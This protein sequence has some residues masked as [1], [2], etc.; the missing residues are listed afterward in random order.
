M[1][2]SSARQS[3]STQTPDA[4]VYALV[5][6]DVFLQQKVLSEVLSRLG[7]D[8]QRADVDGTTAEA[9]QVFDELR[10]FAMFG[11]SRVVVVRDGDEFISRHR[12]ALE[13]YLESP[14]APGTN[15]LVL[16]CASLPKNQRVY[17]LIDKVGRIVS[18]EPPS[19]RDL[20]RWVIGHGQKAH[21]LT[22][23]RDAAALLA[24]CIGNDLGS[25]DNELAKLFL[26]TGDGRVSAELIA[27]GVAFRREQ[28]MWRMTDAL[29]AGRPEEALRIWRQLLATDSSAEFRAVTWLAIWLERSLGALRLADQGRNAFAIAREL[30]IWPAGNAEPLLRTARE[31]GVTRLRRATDQLAEMDYRSKRGLGEAT[32]AVE[33]FILRTA[34]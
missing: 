16:R 17:K 6:S 19:A 15:V 7:S 25:L 1:P 12:P 4:T 32:R 13:A 22:V 2:A 20:P 28:E 29:A 11:G 23:T 5:G 34:G 10:S 31:L 24:D 3:R 18:C 26:Q 9:V 8:V 21:S 30:S 27:G 14:G 33:D